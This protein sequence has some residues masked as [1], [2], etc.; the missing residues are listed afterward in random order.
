MESTKSTQSMATKEETEEQN[1]VQLI[2]LLKKIKVI[3]SFVEK[4]EKEP[5]YL[6]FQQEADLR[7]Q[8]LLKSK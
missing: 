4:L 8:E 7:Q 3:S 5:G 6:E 2:N 1:M